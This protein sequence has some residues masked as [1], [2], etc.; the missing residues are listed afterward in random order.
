VRQPT[1]EQQ[2]QTAAITSKDRVNDL[3]HT[4]TACLLAFRIA[5]LMRA[6]Q[7]NDDGEQRPQ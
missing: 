3:A 4:L 5:L 1:A 2:T 6:N 7:F